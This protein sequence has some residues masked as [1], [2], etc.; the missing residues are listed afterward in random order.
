LRSKATC[1]RYGM[2]SHVI[3]ISYTPEELIQAISAM[4]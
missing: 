4:A 2:R 1:E 3:S